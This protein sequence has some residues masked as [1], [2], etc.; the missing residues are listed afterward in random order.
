[1][2]SIAIFLFIILN[3]NLLSASGDDESSNNALARGFGD[4][5]NWIKFE[6]S[7]NVALKTSKPIFLL[8]HKSWCGACQNLKPKLAESD[9]FKDLSEKFVM[10]NVE[11]IDISVK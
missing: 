7:A 11:V 9:K 1:M 2:I 8:I 4:K 10:V 5:I 6:E 3:N